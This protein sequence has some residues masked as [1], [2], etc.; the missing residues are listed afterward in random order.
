MNRII[1]F[2][3]VNRKVSL[4]GNDPQQEPALAQVLEAQKQ[5]VAAGGNAPKQ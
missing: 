1:V 5:V 2:D 4:V 3:Y